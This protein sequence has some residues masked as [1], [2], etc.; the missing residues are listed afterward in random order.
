MD[1]MDDDG[2]TV[3]AWLDEMRQRTGTATWHRRVFAIANVRNLAAALTLQLA[4]EPDKCDGARRLARA[5]IQASTG[6]AKRS[7]FG[8]IEWLTNGCPRSTAKAMPESEAERAIR[9]RREDAAAAGGRR[10]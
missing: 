9:E 3:D 6:G 8:F 10:G 1:S 7:I 2:F 5:Y 4:K